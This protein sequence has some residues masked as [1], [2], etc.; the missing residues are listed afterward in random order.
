M[1]TSSLL[2]VTLT[3]RNG[4]CCVTTAKTVGMHPVSDPRSWSFLRVI[5]KWTSFPLFYLFF[6]FL[7]PYLFQVLSSLQPQVLALGAWIKTWRAWRPPQENW[8]GAKKKRKARIRQQES[9]QVSVNNIHILSLLEKIHL[10]PIFLP[11][12]CQQAVRRRRTRRRKWKSRVNRKLLQATT[13]RTSC[14]FRDA[15]ELR[16]NLWRSLSSRLVLNSSF[17][18]RS[19]TTTQNT[20]TC[21]KKQ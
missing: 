14:F 15:V 2:Q 17:F 11:G 3:T 21:W 5:G 8:G 4:F 19:T 18:G 6:F 20:M 1:V 12:P 10:I 13:A 7:H 9:L 16:F